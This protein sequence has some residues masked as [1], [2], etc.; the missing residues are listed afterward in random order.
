[1]N[2]ANGIDRRWPEDSFCL[3]ALRHRDYWGRQ[4]ER[5]IRDYGPRHLLIGAPSG[6]GKSVSFFYPTLNMSWFGSA[7]I[8]D[9]KGA[10]YQETAGRRAQFSHVLR[11]SPSDPDTCRR[12]PLSSIRRGRFAIR[13]ALNLAHM[14]PSDAG[15]DKESIWQTT[16]VPYAAAVILHLLTQDDERQKCLAGVASALSRGADLGQEMQTNQCPDPDIRTFI[17]EKAQKLWQN[18]NDRFVW[19]VQANVESWLEP[20]SDPILADATRTSDFS[21]SDLMCGEWP[22]SLYLCPSYGDLD[23]LEPVMRLMIAQIMNELLEHEDTDREGN[24]K[25]HPLGWFLDEFRIGGKQGDY[26]KS[27]VFKRSAHMRAMIG[28][29]ALSQLIAL[30]GP[31]NDIFNNTRFAFT[32]QNWIGE[33]KIISEMIGDAPE[34][35]ESQSQSRHYGE[36][37]GSTSR[38][39]STSWRRVMQADVIRMHEDEVLIFGEPKVIKAWRTPMHAWQRLQLPAPKPSELRPLQWRPQNNWHGH[40]YRRAAT[41]VTT[42]AKPALPPKAKAL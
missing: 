29:Q 16:G 22:V 39:Q 20:Y 35:R 26:A 42:S 32:R 17:T 33:G 3:G 6:S 19:S 41:T 7:F 40:G 23:R 34:L 1:M 30:Y 27:I 36:M 11:F 2:H 13:D 14:L 12:N 15:G 38:S 24:P 25:L 31:N 4:Q 5:L 28:V 9:V 8:L 10:I 18:Q 37:M 21:P